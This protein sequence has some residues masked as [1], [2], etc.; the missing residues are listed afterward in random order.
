MNYKSKKN[1]GFALLYSVLVASVLLAIGLAIFNITIK[2]LL[3]SSLGRDSQFAFYAADTGAECALYWDFKAGAFASS[4]PS[5]I[6]CADTVIDDMGGKPYGVPNEFTLD[7]SPEPY[8][9]TVSVTKYDAPLRTV[10]ESRG[11]NTCDVTNPRR[12]E[13]A[14]RAT[15]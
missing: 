6:E 4:T 15:Y 13:R 5:S 12:V 14:I 2:E 8:C 9:V 3:L 11:Y 1:K 10:I 7:F